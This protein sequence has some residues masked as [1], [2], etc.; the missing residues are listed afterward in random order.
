MIVLKNIQKKYKVVFWDFDGVI[1]NSNEIREYAFMETLK[2]HDKQKVRYLIDYHR[3]NGGLSRY[4]KFK[5][6]YEKILNESVS[7]KKILELAK[8]FSEIVLKKILDKNLLYNDIINYIE[9]NFKNQKMHIV[10]G[11]D[12]KEL[13]FIC[14]K[15]NLFK[16]FV[17]ING[18]PK[19]K[20]DLVLE[21]LDFYNYHKV[22]CCLI[23]DSINDLDAADIN[24]IDFY[25]INNL[26]LINKGNGYIY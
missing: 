3:D 4:V 14:K 26:K 10:S 16:F 24:N 13:N 11:S 1:I 25:G 5:Y 7:E 19:H 2:K 20:N 15:L 6:F 21:I 23:G 12:D 22:D 8:T 9:S 18:S 17:T